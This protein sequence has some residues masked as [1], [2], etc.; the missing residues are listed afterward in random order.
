MHSYAKAG[1]FIY[2][3]TV[4][5]NAGATANLSGNITIS[6]ESGD[7]GTKDNPMILFLAILL[8]I[9]VIG[10]VVIVWIIRRR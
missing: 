10:V 6:G 3:F 7:G 9:I 4:T 8:I 5:D 2:S 1:V